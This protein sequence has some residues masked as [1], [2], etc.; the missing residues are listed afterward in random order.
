LSLVSPFSA[1]RGSCVV[2]KEFR[3][4]WNTYTFCNVFVQKN[5]DSRNFFLL[6]F[7]NQVAMFIVT[8]CIIGTDI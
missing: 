4:K 6:W 8:V 5:S 7:V 1:W 2:V 3:F